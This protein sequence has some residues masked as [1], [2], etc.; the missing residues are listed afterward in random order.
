LND[1][2]TPPDWGSIFHRARRRIFG[3]LLLVAVLAAIGTALLLGGG[4]SAKGSV[5]L[6]PIGNAS[7]T[8]TDTAPK[9]APKKPGGQQRTNEVPGETKSN[10]KANTGDGKSSK[11]EKPDKQKKHHAQWN[12]CAGTSAGTQYC[13]AP[14]EAGGGESTLPSDL[15]D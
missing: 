12:P 13:D 6:G 14:E 9:Q 1:P 11:P 5:S 7:D 10:G 8:E 2:G 3:R 15:K 4:L